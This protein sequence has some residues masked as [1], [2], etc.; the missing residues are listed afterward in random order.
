MSPEPASLD[1]E[2]DIQRASTSADLPDDESFRLW[3]GLAL[4][5]RPG[6]ELTIRL[7]DEE[8]SQALNR[9]YRHKDY[10]TNVLSFPADLPPELNIPLLGD[11][12]VCAP[13]VAREAQEQG[14][15]LQAHWA[16]MVIHGCLHLTGYDHIEDAE[17]DEME[18][19]ERQLLAQLGIADPYLSESL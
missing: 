10:P 16:H 5:N 17:A 12:V 8:E 3:A 4:Q 19:L 18:S 9:D 7:V 1:L 14:K 2:L 13:V 15:P 11:L 6:H